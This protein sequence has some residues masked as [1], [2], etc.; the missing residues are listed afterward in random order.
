MGIS[1]FLKN[2]FGSAKDSAATI[3][4]KVDVNFA[5]AKDAETP[6]I[7]KAEEFAEET[8]SKATEAT[9]ELVTKAEIALEDAKL[10]AGPLVEMAENY[11]GQAKEVISEFSHEA[12]ETID[13]TITTLSENAEFAKDKINHL[14]SE[15]KESTTAKL[16][17]FENNNNESENKIE[18]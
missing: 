12:S 7:T 9:K 10:A 4:D 13:K 8:I 14:T 15:L 5:Q 17:S 3:A 11:A 2:L 18:E 1:S 6:Y 16:K